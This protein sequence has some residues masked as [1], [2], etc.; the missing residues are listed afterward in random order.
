M[1]ADGIVD[2]GQQRTIEPQCNTCAFY[3]GDLTCAA[4]HAR[5]PLAILSGQFDHRQPYEGDGG[6]RYEPEPQP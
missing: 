3:H 6:I 4:F 1:S 5:I 2:E